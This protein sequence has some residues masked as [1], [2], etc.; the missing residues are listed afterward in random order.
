M[1]HT[2]DLDAVDPFR[3]QA[4]TRGLCR[5]LSRELVEA[6]GKRSAKLHSGTRHPSRAS[7]LRPSLLQ[8]ERRNVG[9]KRPLQT[10]P[11]EIF[12]RMPIRRHDE[13]SA[14]G[15]AELDCYVGMRDA[16]L[17]QMRRTEVP[18]LVEIHSGPADAART[19]FQ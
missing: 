2:S 15:V 5:R 13:S 10:L 1:D 7:Q 18:E 17:E 6:A 4:P 9:R 19:G 16:E 3:T 11:S 8:S 12:R 14:V